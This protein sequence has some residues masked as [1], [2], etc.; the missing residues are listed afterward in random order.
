MVRAHR[1]INDD[2]TQLNV[3]NNVGLTTQL[4]VSTSQVKIIFS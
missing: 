1:P 2:G 3:D 4:Q